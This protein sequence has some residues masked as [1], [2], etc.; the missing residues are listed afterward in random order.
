M[1]LS[2]A[3]LTVADMRGISLGGKRVAPMANSGTTCSVSPPHAAVQLLRSVTKAAISAN[4]WVSDIVTAV[5]PQRNKVKRTRSM[6]GFE[7]CMVWLSL[8]GSKCWRVSK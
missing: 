1:N 5:P 6:G 4:L 8:V 2:A 7:T 3:M